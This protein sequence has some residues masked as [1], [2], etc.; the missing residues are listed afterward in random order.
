MPVVIVATMTTDFSTPQRPR[1]VPLSDRLD[2]EWARLSQRPA[3]LERV[4]GWHVTDV[5]FASLDEL[6][7]L[8]GRDVDP[9]PRSDELLRR[10]VEL[11]AFEP[12]A[13]RIV[14][15]RILP[16]LLA[17]V[18]REQLRDRFVDAFELL[19]ADAWLSIVNYRA[20]VRRTNVAARLLSDA[21]HRA[22]TAQRRLRHWTCEELVPP[23]RLDLPR[24]PAPGSSFEE[25]ILVISDARQSGLSDDDL[26]VVRDYVSGAPADGIAARRNISTRTLRNHRHRTIKRL[27]RMAAA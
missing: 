19:I 4:R 13:A 3:V 24:L 12:L 9:T 6:L 15:Q 23:S 5:P 14:L 26:G 27:Q 21:R 20:D 25:L 22:F 1:R 16:G 17:I 18:R 2:R 10:L 7:R 11:A 8:C